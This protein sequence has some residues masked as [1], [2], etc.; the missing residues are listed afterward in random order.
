VLVFFPG[1]RFASS[2]I[3]EEK[4]KMVKNEQRKED[5]EIIVSK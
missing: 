1:S 5:Q 4:E 2:W 3:V